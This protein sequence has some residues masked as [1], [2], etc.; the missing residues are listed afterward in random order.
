MANIKD[1]ARLAGVSL[2]TVSN[3]LNHPDRVSQE[4]RERVEHA[5]D[6]LGFVRNEPA[7][8][9]RAGQSR[10]IAVVV[11]DIANPFFAD[12]IAGAE[13]LAAEQGAQV[14][15]ATATV[16]RRGRPHICRTSASSGSWESCCHPSRRRPP[17]SC[18]PL[19]ATARPWRSSTGSRQVRASPPY[20]SMTCTWARWSRAVHCRRA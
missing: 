14:I 4:L 7:R 17:P 11:L 9:V 16:T 6:D 15:S 3:V 18:S 20:P 12:L 5:I 2:G 19:G 1:V 10:T 8:Q 13:D